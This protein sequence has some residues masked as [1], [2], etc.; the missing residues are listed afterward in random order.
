M[1]IIVFISFAVLAWALIVAYNTSKRREVLLAKYGSAEIVERIMKKMFW[2]G[3]TREQLLDSLGSPL[4]VDQSV[5]KTK[6]K[7]TWKYNSIGKNRY[8]LRVILENNIV[9]GWDQK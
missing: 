9:V 5:L 1:E 2:Q 8:A 7:E 6:V 4:S 3:Q